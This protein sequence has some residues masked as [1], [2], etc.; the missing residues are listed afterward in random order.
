VL[1]H[2]LL[3]RPALGVEAVVLALAAVL[4]PKARE[5]GLWAISALGGALLAASLLPVPDVAAI[6]LVVSVWATCTAVA[7]R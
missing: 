7:L 5:R 2:A 6:P 4:L 1:W 3:S